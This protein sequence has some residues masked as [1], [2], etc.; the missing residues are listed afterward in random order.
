MRQNRIRYWMTPLII[1]VVFVGGYF[2]PIPYYITAPGG[3]VELSPIIKVEGGYAE[4]GSF[5]LTTVRMTSANLFNYALASFDEYKEKIPKKALLANYRNEEE[6]SAR[7][8]FV[9]QSSQNT[10]IKVAYELAGEDVKVSST[11]VIVVGTVEGMPAGEYLSFGDVILSVDDIKVETSEEL[12]QYVQ[13]KQEGDRVHLVYRTGE[14]QKEATIELV[15]FPV[16]DGAEST[17]PPRAGI[18]ISTATKQDI[19]V[20]PPIEIN[21]NR[22]GGPSAG[23]MF[24]LEI[25]NQ[26]TEEDITKGYQIAGTGEIRLDGTVGR[27]GGVH[28]KIVAADKAN[29]DI[30]FAPYEQGAANSNYNRAVEAAQD[31][32]TEMKIVPV[33][34]VH[35]ALQYLESLPPKS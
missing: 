22:I 29:A 33:N 34:T 32:G 35:D 6:Y 16:E 18:G 8:L 21:T 7:Q 5:M 12:I 31:I 14:E 30:F 13:G 3:A 23:L 19:E 10:A 11:E 9:M 4:E 20:D 27:I 1:L 2:Y 17:T 25:Y 28:Q 26:L 15:P 24:T